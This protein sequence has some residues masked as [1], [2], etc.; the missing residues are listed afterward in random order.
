MVMRNDKMKNGDRYEIA[1]IEDEAARIAGA[2]R[3]EVGCGVAWNGAMLGQRLV[4][5]LADSPL[6]DDP[7]LYRGV[8]RHPSYRSAHEI[9]NANNNLRRLEDNRFKRRRGRRLR[10]ASGG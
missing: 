5:L 2:L 1:A 4:E 10:A 7:R 6:G 9:A 3:D 8:L